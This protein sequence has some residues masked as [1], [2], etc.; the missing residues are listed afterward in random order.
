MKKLIVLLA[1]LFVFAACGAAGSGGQQGG[2]VSL[3]PVITEILVDLGFADEI[4]ATDTFSTDIPGLSGDLTLF[5]MMALDG[6]TLMALSPGIVFESDIISDIFADEINP[7]TLLAEAGV[8][9]ARVPTATTVDEIYDVIRLIAATMGVE[10]RGEEI[11]A[12]MVAEIAEIEAV[13]SGITHHRTVYFEISPAPM[14]FSFGSGTFLNELLTLVG[15]VNV[16]ADH[17]GW[18]SVSD[19]FILAANPDVILTNE[20]FMP[21]PVSE[22]ASRPGWNGLDAVAAGRVYQID[23][24]ATSRANHNVVIALRQMAAAIYPEYFTP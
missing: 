10:A 17:D 24:N 19:E 9:V 5:D 14:T 13:A 4:I 20:G 15:G 23:T 8:T 21:D 11:I 12:N 6:E 7:M 16:F 22:I 18:I 2:I 1:G 3:G